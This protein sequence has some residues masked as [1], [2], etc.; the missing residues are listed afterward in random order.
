MIDRRPRIEIR[1]NGPTGF[2]VALSSAGGA[3]DGLLAPSPFPDH[4]RAMHA[5]RALG[6]A[7]GWPV[8][9]RT[10]GERHHDQL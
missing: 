2:A 5:A 10:T 9:D 4:Y 1:R 7:A 3:L 6:H 8:I